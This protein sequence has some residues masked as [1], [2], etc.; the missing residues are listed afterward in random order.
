MVVAVIST[1]D[2][3]AVMHMETVGE[4]TPTQSKAL[5]RRCC[6]VDLATAM[7]ELGIERVTS[8]DLVRLVGTA[9]AAH[10]DEWK[11]YVDGEDKLAGFF[12][13]KVMAATSGN[14]NGREVAAMLRAARSVDE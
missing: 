9:I 5:C 4:I 11:R 1:E 12:T 8:D 14:A 10:P 6:H 13:G 7:G 3:V 2:F